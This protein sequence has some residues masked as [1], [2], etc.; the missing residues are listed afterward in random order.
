V[1]VP[2]GGPDERPGLSAQ[3]AVHA[4]SALGILA[5]TA[6]TFLGLLLVTF[7][8]GRAHV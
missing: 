4:F 6:A 2:A 8:I 7:Q 3:A 5:Q 1:T